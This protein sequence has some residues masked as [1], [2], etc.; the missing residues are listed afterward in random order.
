MKDLIHIDGAVK[1]RIPFRGRLIIIV[2]G[3]VIIIGG[4]VVAYSTYDFTQNN[5][6][7]CNKCHIME[8]AFQSWEKSEHAGINCH[9]CHHL[10]I[11]ELN[12]LLVSF[13][14]RRTESVPVRYGK[15]IVPWKYCISCHWE[16]NREF[17]IAK[18]INSSRIHARHYFMEKIE[19]SKCHGYRLHKFTLE[20]KYCLECHK[21]R[22]V[23]AKGMEELACL[24]CHTDR[25]VDLKP[26]RKK[27]LFCHGDENVRRELDTGDTIDVKH[28]RPSDEVIKHATKI[29]VSKDSPMQFFCYECH[30][31]HDQVRPDYGTCLSCH[32]QIINVGKHKTHVQNMGL[33]CTTCHMKHT[34]RVTEKNAQ[35]IC[36]ECHEYKDPMSFISF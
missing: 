23:H 32:P 21:G 12:Q 9:K 17:P 31:P 22:E 27:C 18:K 30:K 35:T 29:K 2:L 4:S 1:R 20:E 19:C 8:P 36:T 26:G 28:F 16:E 33:E 7:F 6:E 15:V 11:S 25:Q 24:N 14:V 3:L 5:P 10:S 34:W 13:L